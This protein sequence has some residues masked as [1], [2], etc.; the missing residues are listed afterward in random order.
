MLTPSKMS[1]LKIFKPAEIAKAVADRQARDVERVSAIH[2]VSKRVLK[3]RIDAEREFDKTLARQQEVWRVEESAHRNTIQKLLSQTEV[4]ELRKKEA[5][6]PIIDR[7]LAVHNKE[8]ELAERAKEADRRDAEFDDK[9]RAYMLRLDQVAERE[10]AAK[11]KEVHQSIQQE[12]LERQRESVALQSK[13]L[14]AAQNDFIARASV[15]QKE[16]DIYEQETQ[17]QTTTNATYR[18]ALDIK[19]EENRVGAI[20]LADLRQTLD[21][22]FK[23]LDKLKQNYG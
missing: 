11:R 15:R 8:G 23:E 18:K 20:R 5:L 9:L 17:I 22:G 13:S 19:A 7:E 3:E 12:G 10:E 2:D 21:A 4:L 16:L 1:S 6:S 14:S